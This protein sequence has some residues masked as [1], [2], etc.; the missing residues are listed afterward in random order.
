MN[1][2]QFSTYP[3]LLPQ[4]KPLGFSFSLVAF[5][6]LGHALVGIAPSCCGFVGSV[7]DSDH[8]APAAAKA[9]AEPAEL[10]GVEERNA[11]L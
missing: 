7:R 8:G 3:Q 10:I 5:S 6:Q 11:R 4:S 9:R 1:S 2:Y